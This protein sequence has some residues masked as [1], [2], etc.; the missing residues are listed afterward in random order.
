[1]IKHLIKLRYLGN[2]EFICELYKRKLLVPSVP[3]HCAG[4]LLKQ[5]NDFISS[6]DSLESLCKMLKFLGGLLYGKSP[7]ALNAIMAELNARVD[8]KEISSRIRFMIQD[9]FDLHRNNWRVPHPKNKMAMR[10]SAPGKG[11]NSDSRSL[12]TSYGAISNSSP[13]MKRGD[14]WKERKGSLS[15][16]SPA[17]KSSKPA[18]PAWGRKS[19]GSLDTTIRKEPEKKPEPEPEPEPEATPEPQIEEKKGFVVSEKVSNSIK[20]MLDEYYM[21]KDVDEAKECIAEMNPDSGADLFTEIVRRILAS[22][23]K[24][25]LVTP[26]T[27]LLIF[28]N[29]QSV[30]KKDHLEGAFKLCFDTIEDDTE[31]LPIL[32]KLYGKIF[33]EL[34]KEATMELGFL[35]EIH[36]QESKMIVLRFNGAALDAIFESKEESEILE[37]L[38]SRGFSSAAL[39]RKENPDRLSR[40]FTNATVMKVVQ[41]EE[42]TGN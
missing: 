36:S 27:K 25:N 3:L 33:G 28:L 14:K 26:A 39:T 6:E 1:M 29:K 18:K 5:E 20:N 24:D 4:E 16:I 9:T 31:E 17:G 10:S 30:L 19:V 35:K 8:D 22:V 37:T 15:N 12:S 13:G 32:P 41:S 21:I 2:I 38:K 23:R 7:Q 40:Y 11:R 34:V 42:L